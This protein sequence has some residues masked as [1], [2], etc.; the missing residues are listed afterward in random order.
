V[1]PRARDRVILNVLIGYGGHPC[2]S[3][4]ILT[5]Q[6]FDLRA[7]VVDADVPEFPASQSPFDI[8]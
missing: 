3:Q 4:V 7:Y 6:V 2:S 1:L 5:A 8:W